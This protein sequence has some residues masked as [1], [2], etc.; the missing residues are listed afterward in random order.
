VINSV[1]CKDCRPRFQQALLKALGDD[2]PKLCQDCQR[3]AKTNPL[4]IYDCKVPAD[5]PI[6]DRLPH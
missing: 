6:I 4:R 3:R 2:L 1:G 5:Q